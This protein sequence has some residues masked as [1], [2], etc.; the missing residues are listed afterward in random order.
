MLQEFT[1]E[2]KNTVSELISGVHTA[3]SGTILSYNSGSGMASI[4]TNGKF[5][6]PDGKYIDYPKLNSVPVLIAQACGQDCTIAYPIKQGDGCLVLFLE[7]GENDVSFDLSNAVALVG[8]F[9]S[10]NSLSQEAQDDDKLI[11]QKNDHRIHIKP[12]EVLIKYSDDVN[13][14]FKADGITLKA[15]KITL[16][17]PLVENTGNAVTKGTTKTSNS[18]VLDTHKHT[19]SIGGNTTSLSN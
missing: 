6:K 2:V 1:Q 19:D 17:T 15:P 16:D 5:K 8:L 11:I 3:I 7:Q 4:S 12:D 13:A 18:L 10:P 9:T 14:L